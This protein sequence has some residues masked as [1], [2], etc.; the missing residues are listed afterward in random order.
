VPTLQDDA[1]Y[2]SLLTSAEYEAARRF[3]GV[4][5]D[6]EFRRRHPDVVEEAEFQANAPWWKKLWRWG[7]G[8]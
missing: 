8:G 6:P 2:L 4:W 7:R 1:R 3:E 5:S